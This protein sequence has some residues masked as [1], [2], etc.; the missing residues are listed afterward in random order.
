MVQVR[1]LRDFY[2]LVERVDRKEGD[3]FE[4]TEERAARIAE[5]LPGYVEVG[6]ADLGSLKLAQLRELAAERGVEIPAKATKAE[7]VELLEG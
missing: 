5:L 1:T 4:A 7:I 6:R 2:D 3:V